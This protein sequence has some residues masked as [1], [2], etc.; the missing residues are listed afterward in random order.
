MPKRPDTQHFLCLLDSLQLSSNPALRYSSSKRPVTYR[1]LHNFARS[2]TVSIVN[3]GFL[4]KPVVAIILPN[5]PLL[6]ATIIAV[7]NFYI[8]APINPSAG[9]DQVR[10]D[11]ELSRAS[12]IISC[13]S[14]ISMLQLNRNGLDIH[15]VNEIDED[16]ARF[17]VKHPES[18]SALQLPTP[19]QPE[20]I[21]MILFTS[22]TSGNRKVVPITI[23]TI[24][25]GVGLVV[26]SWGLTSNDICLNMM[27][28]YHIGGIIRNLFAPLFSG[29]STICCTNFDP[30]LFW[31]QVEDVQPTWYYASPTMHSMIL[32]EGTNRQTALMKSRIR[33][34]CNAA[35]G[36]LPALAEQIRNTFQCTVLPSYGMTECM[37]I[38]TPSLSY[39]LD[40]PGTS[41]LVTGP[42][43][44]IL[45]AADNELSPFQTGRICLRGGPLFQGY[46][47]ADGSLD[48]SPFSS[49]GWFDTGDTGYLDKDEF[50]YITGRNKEVINRGG[51]II[52]PF[53]VENAVIAAATQQESPTFQR[54]S[55]ALAFSV[56]HDTLQEVVGVV[57]V[58]PYGQPKV[59]LRCLHK[60]LRSSLQQAKWPAV[61]V[62]MDDVPRRNNKVLR[63][64]LGERLDIPCMDDYTPFSKRHFTARCPPAETDLSISIPSALCLV[65]AHTAQRQIRQ[66]L[67]PEYEIYIESMPQSGT[68][69]AY[70][71]H[72]THDGYVSDDEDAESVTRILFAKIDG[73]LVPHSIITISKPLPRNERGEVDQ[74]L[75]SKLVKEAQFSETT[76]LADT[77]TQKLTRVFADLLQLRI[78]DVL[79]HKDFFELGGDS[80][81]A[82][83][84]LSTVRAEFGV[85][86][87]IDYIFKHGS[88]RQLCD[89]I[90]EELSKRE[91]GAPGDED[92]SI[93][94][95]QKLYSSTNPFLLLLQL[96]P[97]M[98]IYPLRR[99][100]SWTLFIYS[101]IYLLGFRTSQTV[102]G[103]LVNVVVSTIFARLVS[104]IVLPSLGI[105]AK[106]VIIGRMKE[107]LYPMWGPYHTRWWL[108]QK[109]VMIAGK[110]IFGWTESSSIW[111][112]RLLGAK[113]GTGVTIKNARLG[114]WDLLDIG[115]N[116]TLDECTV[117][118]M[119][120]ERNTM[121]YLGKITIG[122]NA[123]VGVGS[124]IAPGATVPDSVCIGPR[125]SSWELQDASEANRDLSAT[126]SPKSHWALSLFFTLPLQIAVI[127]L[128]YLPWLLGLIGLVQSEA[129]H[130]RSILIRVIHWFTQGERVGWYYLARSLRTF[131]GPV[132]VFVFTVIVRKLL[133]A[134][135]GP[136]EPSATSERGNVDRWRMS[137]MKTLM[138][139][140]KLS[141]LTELFG[142]HYEAT[143][144][145]VRLLGG[146]VG[147]YVYW[148]GTGPSIGDYELLDIGNNV[149]FGSRSHLINVDGTG[150]DYITIKDGAMIADRVVALPGIIV[151][152][153]ATLGSGCLTKRDK[154]YEPSGTY[155]GSKGGDSVFLGARPRDEKG[156][157]T[158]PLD[159][160]RLRKLIYPWRRRKF[161]RKYGISPKVTISTLTDK[162]LEKAYDSATTKSGSPANGVVTTITEVEST[163][164]RMSPFGRA[165][166]LRKAPYFVWRQWM[167]FIYSTLTVIFTHAY[168]TAASISS[169]QVV[170][171]VFENTLWLGN[172]NWYDP[173]I[174]FLLCSALLSA[175]M[176]VQSLVAVAFVIAAKWILLGRRQPGNYDWD[177][178]SYCQRWQ[179][180][181]AIER[182]RR[183]CFGGHGVLGMFTG[184]AYM[185][186]YFR[187]LG[188]KIGKDCALFVNGRPSLLFTE[189]D[190]LE[191]GD[192]VVVDDASL[193]GHINTRGKFDLN[194]L[195]VG[196]RCVL[197]TNSRLLSGARME[198]D[199]CLLE[200]TLVMAGDIVEQ[201]ETMQGWPASRFGGKRTFST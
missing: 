55:Q 143:S 151:G 118:P 65:A 27:P 74:I 124:I 86:I 132:F 101:L 178:S 49:Q 133:S 188:A 1:E 183:H 36:L 190:L 130:M 112:Y 137:L 195:Y 72:K 38:S 179:L 189:P 33:L 161:D 95:T 110:G 15:F 127:F 139:N 85:R 182:I 155:V 91:K 80:L 180:F 44:L 193:V 169:I 40:R 102:I 11:I 144:V 59:D 78:K 63:V 77:T 111:Y 100:F 13:T 134:L 45:D 16:G 61:I 35:G 150:S 128:Y 5:G 7:S 125:S 39:S 93:S 82:G 115:D 98:L 56:R 62:Y 66:V 18:V 21:A 24:L 175:L 142:Q 156:T 20:D 96:T 14:E 121:M 148:P 46:L 70:L 22:G 146:K 186:W 50:L 3:N 181:L 30:N 6:A 88:V 154:A 71:S 37:P 141:Q 9:P 113:I 29:G 135:F 48:N 41:G 58:T 83:K 90:E 122:Q 108:T 160:R 114:E 116:A 23:Q 138:P 197:R 94:G 2:F 117:R 69:T 123:S 51:E 19:N 73:Y 131:F 34:V 84:L 17:E 43:L 158:E 165:F 68:L 57:L 145:A 171:I 162:G 67:P 4:K 26:D 107:G 103:R 12:A 92:H 97:L 31:D 198:K 173:F 187:A 184:T 126:K 119:A 52:S 99:A 166:Y 64:K 176:A 168:W 159:L 8:A 174:L 25:I 47:R 76:T 89:Y 28:L 104:S 177:K 157:V 200:N 192:R 164:D 79:P 120:G 53:E 42:E 191:M 163:E 194:R 129:E 81:R 147:R 185:T 199:S 105:V 10:A 106:W 153:E 54:I 167:I 170:A 140:S 152:A 87:P 172:G 201:G 32:G 136:L 60:S 196:D 149:V 109:I 75:L